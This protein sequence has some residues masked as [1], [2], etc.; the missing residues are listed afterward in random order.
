[1]RSTYPPL[2][3]GINDAVAK[4]QSTAPTHE[5]SRA[6]LLDNGWIRVSAVRADET[7]GEVGCKG[8]LVGLRR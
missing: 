5:V 3:S 7:D 8:S 2:T 1:M 6:K 4:D